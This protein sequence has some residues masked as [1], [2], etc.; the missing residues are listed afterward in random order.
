M[1]ESLLQAHAR[2]LCRRTLLD[3]GQ[4]EIKWASRKVLSLLSNFFVGFSFSPAIEIKL[5]SDFS[6]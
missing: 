2:F 3:A 5:P 4:S 1:N 6:F